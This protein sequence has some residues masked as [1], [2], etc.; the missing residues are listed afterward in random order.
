MTLKTRFLP[1]WLNI[2]AASLLVF[3][4]LFVYAQNAPAPAA[5]APAKAAPT[6]STADRSQ[7]YYHVALASIYEDDATSQGQAEFVN[8]AIEEYKLALNADPGSPELSDALA[9]LYFRIPGHEHD[10]E[11]TARNLLKTSPNDIPAH[12][13]LGRLYLRQLGEGD[14]ASAP[15]SNSDA[16]LAQ[17]IS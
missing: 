11:V 12:K 17:S 16:I 2:A 5:S 4:A 7:A 14:N 13:L 8:R 1:S 10:A 15:P 6:D 3:P 9:D